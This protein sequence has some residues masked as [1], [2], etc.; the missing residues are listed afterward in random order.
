M[1]ASGITSSGGGAATAGGMDYQN[2]VA[3]WLAVRILAEQAAPLPWGLSKPGSS[4]EFIR[5][6]TEQ[7]VDDILVGTSAS[8]FAFIQVKKTIQLSP[9]SNSELASCFG[10]FVR[11]FISNLAHRSKAARPW[12]RP[13]DQSKDRLVLVTTS[14]SSGKI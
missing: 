12:E 2:K 4:P 3:A 8:G 13:L 11:Q 6:E 7:P 10:Q 9:D 5:C 1:A 14:K